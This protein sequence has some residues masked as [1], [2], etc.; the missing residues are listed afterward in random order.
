HKP[1]AI[2]QKPD[3]KP[4]LPSGDAPLPDTPV[5]LNGMRLPEDWQPTAEQWAY[6]SERG[7]VSDQIELMVEDFRDYWLAKPGKDARKRDWNRT[8]RRWVRNQANFRN[9]GRTSGKPTRTVETDR[10]AILQG[11]GLD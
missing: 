3:I 11:L 2:S 6:A 1:E 8:W 10:R 5:R 4:D 7:Y 9:G